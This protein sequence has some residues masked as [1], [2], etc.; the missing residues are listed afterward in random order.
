MPKNK[1]IERAREDKREGKAPS[2]QA[3]EFM[4]E[5]I[6]LICKGAHGARSTKQAIAIGLSKARGSEAAAAEERDGVRRDAREGEARSGKSRGRWCREAVSETLAG[7]A[8]STQTRAAWDRL[9]R[10]AREAGSR[11]GAE[12]NAR[13]KIVRSEDKVL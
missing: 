5:E 8:Q 1:T 12:T 11:G 6:E 9:E 13:G 10:S 7:H 3:G 2:T 4:R